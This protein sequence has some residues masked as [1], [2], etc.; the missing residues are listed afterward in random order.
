MSPLFTLQIKLLKL[1]H[2][3]QSQHLNHQPKT[4]PTS[5][6][7][8]IAGATDTHTATRPTATAIDAAIDIAAKYLFKNLL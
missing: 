5:S 8:I 3:L 7:K 4:L 2:G 1:T 6:D